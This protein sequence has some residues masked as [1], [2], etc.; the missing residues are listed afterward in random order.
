MDDPSSRLAAGLRS[1]DQSSG[2]DKTRCGNGHFASR[3][4][5]RAALRRIEDALEDR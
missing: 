5:N 1:R 2:R 3:Q 4:H